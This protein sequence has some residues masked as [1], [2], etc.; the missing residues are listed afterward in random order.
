[1]NIREKSEVCR[2]NLLKNIL[3]QE[4]QPNYS[5]IRQTYYNSQ[6][7]CLSVK[8]LP[9]LGNKNSLSLYVYLH[10]CISVL[11]TVPFNISLNL[12]ISNAT[13]FS[14][15][16]KQHISKD[17]SYFPFMLTSHK[18]FS[19]WTRVFLYT[20]LSQNLILNSS[21]EWFLGYFETL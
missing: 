19:D 14:I 8:R 7:L 21:T 6:T 9:S 10:L 18:D 3:W 4:S 5:D 1:M 11:I 12:F 16:G 15:C 20:P 13:K 2:F 17:G